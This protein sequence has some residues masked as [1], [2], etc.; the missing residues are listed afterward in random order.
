MTGVLGCGTVAAHEFAHAI[1]RARHAGH[2]DAVSLA[3]ALADRVLERVADFLEQ[4][5][6]LGHQVGHR[7]AQVI[8]H[9]G[10]TGIYPD[11]WP[12]DVPC[13][14]QAGHGLEAVLLG[15][16]QLQGV[17]VVEDFLERALLDIGGQ[18]VNL[19]IVNQAHAVAR[20]GAVDGH[21]RRCLVVPCCATVRSGRI[22]ISW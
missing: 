18:T 17:T 11:Q 14:A 16:D 22:V 3:A 10:V 5:R 21:G 4:L 12:F 1:H 9:I 6:R 13:V 15:G 2:L 19:G 7:R 8:E 20:D